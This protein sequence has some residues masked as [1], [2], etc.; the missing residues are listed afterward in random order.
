MGLSLI[1]VAQLTAQMGHTIQG[2]HLVGGNHHSLL[3]GLHRFVIALQVLIDVPQL[4]VDVRP[5]GIQ[6]RGLLQVV[7]GLLIFPHLV[8]RLSQLEVIIT[9]FRLQGRGLEIGFHRFAIAAIVGVKVSQGLEGRSPI[10]GQFNGPQ[11]GPIGLLLLTRQVGCPGQVDKVLRLILLERCHLTVVLVSQ[12]IALQL[13]IE[14]SQLEEPL[15]PLR[16]QFQRPLQGLGS[17][18]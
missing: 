12:I 2:L 15:T 5:V 14:L 6:H 3:V 17:L 7:N 9:P 16:C 11:Q 4:G 10:L 13:L 8:Q 18:A 1:Q